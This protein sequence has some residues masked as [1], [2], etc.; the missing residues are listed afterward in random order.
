MGCDVH[1]I[2][3][4]RPVSL[5]ELRDHVRRQAEATP[6][7]EIP[8]FLAALVAGMEIAQ[9]R[10]VSTNATAPTIA[11][12]ADQPNGYITPEG[13]AKLMGVPRRRI[14]A[15]AKGKKWALRVSRKC[16]RIDEAGFRRWLGAL[17]RAT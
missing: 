7:A 8:A 1:P 10:L 3:I 5:A 12:H 2:V 11:G 15:L 9:A 13:A 14:Y 16:L 6:V 17:A 4:R